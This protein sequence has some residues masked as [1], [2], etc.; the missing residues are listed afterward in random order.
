MRRRISIAQELATW[1]DAMPGLLRKLDVVLEL[2]NLTATQRLDIELITV[3]I[4]SVFVSIGVAVDADASCERLLAI[5]DRLRD[6]MAAADA[7]LE[8][9]L[10]PLAN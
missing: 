3:R 1:S 8:G 4:G 7:T 5:V 10:K 9:L 6:E 2:S